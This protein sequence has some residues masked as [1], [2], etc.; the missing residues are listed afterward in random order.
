MINRTTKHPLDTC[1]PTY[2][3]TY[4]QTYVIAHQPTTH[5]PACLHTIQLTTHTCTENLNH[6]AHVNH[7]GVVL[8]TFSY[9]CGSDAGSSRDR[10]AIVFG[11]LDWFFPCAIFGWI[12]SFAWERSFGDIRSRPSL[13]NVCS[14]TIAREMTFGTIV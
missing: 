9:R 1:M 14:G 7:Y 13:G 10:F 8:G 2:S 5:L 6:P 3:L 11:S 12:P 4:S